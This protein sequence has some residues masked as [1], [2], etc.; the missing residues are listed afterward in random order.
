MQEKIFTAVATYNK[1]AELSEEKLMR[2]GG[3]IYGRVMNR[4]LEI[5]AEDLVDKFEYLV[6]KTDDPQELFVFLEDNIPYLSDIIIQ[7]AEGFMKEKEDLL[8]G[9]E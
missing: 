5:M 4:A 2:V 9:L 8:E 3:I 6:E 7:E 1:A